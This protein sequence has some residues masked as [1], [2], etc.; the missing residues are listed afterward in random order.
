MRDN[1][2]IIWID[3][4]RCIAC[5]LVI[6]LHTSAPYLSQNI[7][8]YA[9]GTNSV[10]YQFA[11]YLDSISRICVPLFFMISGYFF[12]GEKKPSRKHFI[13]ILSSLVFYS[14]FAFSLF[15]F[16]NTQKASIYHRWG[17]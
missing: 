16:L 2:K 15:E 12:F 10:Y 7:S 3:Y 8:S 17:F 6:V 9:D 1:K 11:N 5:L 13:K 14:L 4:I